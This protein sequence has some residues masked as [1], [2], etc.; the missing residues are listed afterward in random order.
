MSTGLCI[1]FCET[2]Y[3]PKNSTGR[4]GR[5]SK[6]PPQFGQTSKSRS[7]TQVAPVQCQY[8]YNIVNVNMCCGNAWIL[9]DL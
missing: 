7:S 1:T 2:G 9:E 5:F 3:F 4:I 8:N 6:F